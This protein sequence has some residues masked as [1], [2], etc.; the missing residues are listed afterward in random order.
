MESKT[1]LYLD[2]FISNDLCH[3]FSLPYEQSFDLKINVYVTVNVIKLVI[4]HISRLLCI[5][6]SPFGKSQGKRKFYRI[7]RLF[8]ILFM[9]N[10]EFECQIDYLSQPVNMYNDCFLLGNV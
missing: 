4:M 9:L 7:F 3:Y 10:G 8:C 6:S 2:I 5:I 1:H